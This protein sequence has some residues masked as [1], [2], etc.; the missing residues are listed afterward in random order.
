MYSPPLL[1]TRFQSACHYHF[2]NIHVQT[3]TSPFGFV[4]FMVFHLDFA[5]VDRLGGDLKREMFFLFFLA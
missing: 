4:F 1:L 3:F 2:K 5:S